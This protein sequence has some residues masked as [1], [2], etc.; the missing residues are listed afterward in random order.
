MASVNR[1]QK[2]AAEEAL[3]FPCIATGFLG[4]KPLARMKITLHSTR[5]L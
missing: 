3:G 1:P 2:K 4:K 5:E